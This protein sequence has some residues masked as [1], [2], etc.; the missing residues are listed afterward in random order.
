[1]PSPGW[2][3]AAISG[4]LLLLLSEVRA[5]VI[6]CLAYQRFAEFLCTC[7][8]LLSVLD[9]RVPERMRFSSAVK[10]LGDELF[11][12]S[13]LKARNQR[14]PHFAPLAGATAALF[15]CAL[16]VVSRRPG[17]AG[18]ATLL[19]VAGVIAL[20]KLK[21]KY[22]RMNLHA[23][24]FVYFLKASS[25]IFFWQNYRA[26]ALG[27][28]GTLAFGLLLLSALAASEPP[29]VS[30]H[31]AGIAFLIAVILFSLAVLFSKPSPKLMSYWDWFDR[32]A[33]L[34]RFMESVFEAVPA[35]RRRGLLA[36]VPAAHGFPELLRAAQTLE[37]PAPNIILILNESTFPPWL[38]QSSVADPSL[39]S[40]FRS[41]D[42]RMHGL[43][44]ETFGGASWKSEFSVLTGIP[45]GC[46]G[47]F[48]TH[49][50]HWAANKIHETLPLRLK[51]LGYRTGMI[52]PFEEDFIDSGRF[53]RSI[54]LDQILSM[55]ALGANSDR[56]P[57][58]FY[59]NA[60]IDW[61][62]GHP[63]SRPGFLYVATMW[64][65]FPHDVSVVDDEGKRQITKI[66]DTEFDEYL[67]RLRDSCA[68]YERFRAG[69]AR[70]YPDR[71]FLIVHYGDHQP[72]LALKLF[73]AKY[74][75]RK[76][77]LSGSDH[78]MLYRTYF[79]IDSV[80]FKPVVD[81]RLPETIEAA[82]LGTVLLDAAGIPPDGLQSARRELMMKHDGR[83]FFAEGEIAAQLNHRLLSAGMVTPH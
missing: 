69:L 75:E 17:V 28:L 25:I 67:R 45:S 20:S 51:R 56:E 38:Y 44:V 41:V 49:V 12:E 14:V 10:N 4:C 64:N 34:S 16:L 80:N 55:S 74:P 47:A 83:L 42:G 3:I 78:E 27:I 46:Y 54:G 22:V 31:V 58:E 19:L 13:Q 2:T 50:F 26:V 70:R 5:L 53:Y 68:A 6:H 15:F 11:R 81:P 21:F 61:F 24:D 52:F 62:A 37:R 23:Y 8:K 35:V 32:P 76:A 43:R 18:L 63:A 73:N 59:L 65:H 33:N 77:P 30:R 82:Y 7:G 9:D 79:A 60:A 40:F 36:S 1:M 48:G 29:E 66:S 72:P 39:T 71:E 57:D